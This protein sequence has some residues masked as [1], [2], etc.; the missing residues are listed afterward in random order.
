[1]ARHPL[2]SVSCILIGHLLLHV[3]GHLLLQDEG[4]C[5]CCCMRV[6]KR[7]LLSFCCAVASLVSEDEDFCS[8]CLE[9]YTQ[10]MLHAAASLVSVIVIPEWIGGA[11]NGTLKTPAKLTLHTDP[12]LTPAN[13]SSLNLTR[14]YDILCIHNMYPNAQ[15]PGQDSS[16]V[17]HQGVCALPLQRTRRYGHNA[18]TTTT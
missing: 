5:V 15:I 14:S 9:G 16:V 11:R 17:S 3:L 10:G 7:V 2:V 18:A 12:I 13:N 1:M 4:V 8:T 6:Y